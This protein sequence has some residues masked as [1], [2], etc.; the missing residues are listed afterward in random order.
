M[1]AANEIDKCARKV[2]EQFH[3]ERIILFGSYAY[4]MPTCDSAADLL[5]VMGYEGRA[6]EQAGKI[7]SFLHSAFSI[8][9]LSV[10]SGFCVEFRY[11]EESADLLMAKDAQKHCRAFCAL[12][13]EAM[14]L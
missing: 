11:P 3:S 8:D 7:R 4:G 6:V 10:L 1:V 12:A 13:R 2:A 5:A 9:A 14:R